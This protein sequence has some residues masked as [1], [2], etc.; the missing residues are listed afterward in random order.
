VGPVGAFLCDDAFEGVQPFLGFLG[1]DVCQGIL[2]V[3][4]HGFVSS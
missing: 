2:R 3:R 4:G 1:I